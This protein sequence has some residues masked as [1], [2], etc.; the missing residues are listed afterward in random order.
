[1]ARVREPSNKQRSLGLEAA[2]QQGVLS[3]PDSLPERARITKGQESLRQMLERLGGLVF[4]VESL[5]SEHRGC[6]SQCVARRGMCRLAPRTRQGER[7]F[8]TMY[9]S[10]SLDGPD[11]IKCS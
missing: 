2:R 3:R 10:C 5:A 6:V 1:M 4:I 9:C 11:N 7:T 8:N